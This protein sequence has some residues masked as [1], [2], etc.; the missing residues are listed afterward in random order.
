MNRRDKRWSAG[1]CLSIAVW[2]T[3]SGCS[4]T[5]PKPCDC[6]A[7]AALYKNETRQYLQCLEDKG[8]LRQQLKAMQQK[9]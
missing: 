8:N 1:I 5:L 7:E 6:G 2:L 9:R 4:Q 3:S